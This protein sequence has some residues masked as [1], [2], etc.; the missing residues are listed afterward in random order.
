MRIYS[1]QTLHEEEIVSGVNVCSQNSAAKS[2]IIP[3]TTLKNLG[4][5]IFT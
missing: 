3:N 4:L 5:N 1:R 2:N